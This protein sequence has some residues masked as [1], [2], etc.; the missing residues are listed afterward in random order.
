MHAS[1]ITGLLAPFWATW[2]L[3][4]YWSP[5]Y[6]LQFSFFN[7][8]VGG[9]EDFLY[10]FCIGGIAS[11]LY[12]VVFGIKYSKIGEG[13]NSQGIRIISFLL[14]FAIAFYVPFCFGVNSIYSAFISFIV[15]GIYMYSIRKDLLVGAIMSAFLVTVVVSIKY[16]I[17]LYIFPNIINEWWHLENL[18][19]IFIREVPAE[20]IIWASMIGFIAG[21]LYEFLYGYRILKNT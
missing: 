7:T 11:V 14:L 8:D 1:I 3:K 6:L 18:S 2:F 21:P 10:G 5:E 4:D 20:E 19:G 13:R 12:E 16:L 15:L 17:F 9:I